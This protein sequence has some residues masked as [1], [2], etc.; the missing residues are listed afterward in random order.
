MSEENSDPHSLMENT[1]DT[2]QS[3][4]MRKIEHRQRLKGGT[5]IESI[6]EEMRQVKESDGEEL[7]VEK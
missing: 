2:A 6:Q 1:P 7:R 3:S 5:S 4:S